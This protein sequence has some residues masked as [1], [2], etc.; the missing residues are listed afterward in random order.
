MV[1]GD[2]LL[3]RVF[4]RFGLR[5]IKRQ[6]AL[7]IAQEMERSEIPAEMAELVRRLAS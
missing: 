1:P 4:K 7:R 2:E 5:F 3:D 6:D